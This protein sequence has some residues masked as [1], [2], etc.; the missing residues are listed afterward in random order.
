MVK[1]I[2]EENF[3]ETIKKGRVLVDCYADW[4]GPCKMLSPVIDEISEELKDINFYK[5]NVDDAEET[6]AEYGIM[7]I[8]TLLLFENGELKEQLVGFRSKDELL[9]ILKK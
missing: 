5:L 6:S 4:C 2:K 7:S 3:K 9:S 1:E 8:P